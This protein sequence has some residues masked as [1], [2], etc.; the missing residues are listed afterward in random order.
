MTPRE[1][2][3]R[4]ARDLLTALVRARSPNPPG[5]E[6]EVANVI[7]DA[8]HRLGLPAPRRYARRA[9]RPNLLLEIGHGQP[10]LLLAAHMDTMPPGPLN[11]WHIDDP[12]ELEEHAGRLVG[13]GCA[14]MKAA[15]ASMLCAAARLV[16]DPPATGT[17]TLAFTA[18]EENGSSEGMAWLCASGL[19][20]PTQP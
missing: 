4:Q 14:D 6:R 5:D 8:S 10:R 15:I 1:Q 18:D 12:F 16:G 2:E 3:L 20:G 19:I 11:S 9:E 13:V 17:L 7:E